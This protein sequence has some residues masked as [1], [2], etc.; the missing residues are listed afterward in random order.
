[1]QKD[2]MI[3]NAFEVALKFNRKLCMEIEREDYK[4]FS[5]HERV[6]IFSIKWNF[7][8]ISCCILFQAVQRVRVCNFS[9]NSYLTFFYFRREYKMGNN[10]IHLNQKAFFIEKRLITQ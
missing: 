4:A 9:F 2:L 7:F 8:I 1:M 6:R 10:C 3:L 5:K